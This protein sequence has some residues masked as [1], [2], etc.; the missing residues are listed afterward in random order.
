MPVGEH[1]AD[2][3]LIPM[4]LA[5]RPEAG[6]HGSRMVTTEPSLHARTN[7]EIIA[8]FMDV[9]FEFEARDAR[10]WEIRVGPRGAG[11][12]HPIAG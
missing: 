6:G 4:A 3:L 1:L 12:A 7:A 9:A 11:D 10:R 2:Q 8:R 5:A